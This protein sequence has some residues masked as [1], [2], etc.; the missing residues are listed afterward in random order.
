MKALNKKHQ[1]KVNKAITWLTKHNLANDQRDKAEGDGDEKMY[2]KYNKI[3][4]KTFD[5]YLEFISELPSREIKQIE[6][7]EL[8]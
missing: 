7:S 6:K 3:C 8:Y 4:E 1:S 2:N 5:K